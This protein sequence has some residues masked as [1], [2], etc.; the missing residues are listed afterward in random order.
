MKQAAIWKISNRKCVPLQHLFG[1]FR[2]SVGGALDIAGAR[3][4]PGICCIICGQT[5]TRS[6]A[7]DYNYT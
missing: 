1:H 2:P 3:G 4:T 5:T 7:S 6:P